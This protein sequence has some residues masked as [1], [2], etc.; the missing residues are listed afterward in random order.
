MNE[1]IHESLVDL[2]VPI[3]HLRTMPD[4]PR[5]GDIDAIKRSY[6]TFGQRKPIVAR[7]D[8]TVI[9]GNH[10][11]EAARQLGWEEIAAVVVDE[12]DLISKAYALAVNKIA[13]KGK[14]NEDYVA[15]L[16]AE[17]VV[18]PELLAATAYTELEVAGM[19]GE[20]V[21]LGPEEILDEPQGK[22]V[23]CPA[24]D[25]SWIPA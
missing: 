6:E 3:D 25:Y 12:D 13:D 21:G 9:D 7:R 10:Q 20:T 8:G 18:D 17:L 16:I 19:L 15:E 5:I 24:C 1:N 11:L 4:N 14:Y 2:I 22:V 23:K